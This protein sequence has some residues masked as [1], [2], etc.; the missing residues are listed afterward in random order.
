M[1]VVSGEAR[2]GNGSSESKNSRGTGGILG[3]G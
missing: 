2:E 3:K 1:G